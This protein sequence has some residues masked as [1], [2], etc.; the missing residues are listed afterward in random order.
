MRARP[1]AAV[2][3]LLLTAGAAPAAAAGPPTMPLVDVHPG[4]RCSATTVIRGTE[5][6]AFDVEVIDV[7]DAG[8]TGEG[9]RILVRVSGPAV[10][11]T[12]V[13]EGFS[14]SPV[15]C[16]DGRGT[17]R[18]I[19][20]LSESIGQYG[21]AVVLATP[22]EAILGTP[23]HPPAGVRIARRLLSAARP[24]PAPLTVSGLSPGLARAVAA[25]SARAGHPLLAAP[26]GAPPPYRVQRLTPGRSVAVGYSSGDLA[27][28][29]IGTVSYADGRSVWAFGHEFEGVGRRA[30]LLQDAYVYDVVA[31]PLGVPG[32][33]SYK[34]AAPG[35][36]VG[37]LSSDGGDAVAGT[38]GRP[39]HTVDLRVR[40]RDGDT[41]RTRTL[42]ARV[43]DEMAVDLPA[44]SSPLTGVAPLGVVQGAVDLLGA[45]P[46][47]LTGTMCLRIALEGRSRPLRACDRYVSASGSP[48]DGPLGNAV[49]GGAATDVANALADLDAYT[50]RPPRVRAVTVGLTLQ[51]GAR[52]AFLG[53]VRAP[54]AVRAGGRAHVRVQLHVVRGGTVTRRYAMAVPAG[55]RPGR[56]VLR[57]AGLDAD[58]GSGGGLLFD[59]FAGGQPSP[60]GKRGPRDL[61]ALARQVAR[62]GR[63]DGVTLRA[64]S[65]RHR[66][67][68]DPGLRISGTARVVLRV[69]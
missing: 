37:T 6:V 23:V 19:G 50:G 55:L 59:V 47:R 44:G 68:R 61:D 31:N 1:L 18:I 46:V 7:V 58:T 48:A 43:A 65:R 24:L 34:L 12:G 20:A 9:A 45:T 69:R 64:G 17:P 67:F 54:G 5:P 42:H 66:A 2:T 63:W 32:L 35:H 16:P 29:A 52:Q 3:A 14:G 56:H 41:G 4:L 62:T 10:D 33:T 27:V 60:A 51:R 49:V 53:R 57:L 13:A 8:T 22:I 21:D 11:A 15:T 30:L 36:T 26:G 39:P 28:G 40:A 38:V 25:A